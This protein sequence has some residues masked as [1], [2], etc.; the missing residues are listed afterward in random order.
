MTE[1]NKT[2]FITYPKTFENYKWYKPILVC[3]R[4]TDFFIDPCFWPPFFG[5]LHDLPYDVD[6][7]SYGRPFQGNFYGFVHFHDGSSTIF[8]IQ[9]YSGQA[10]FII[11]LHTGKM[12]L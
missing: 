1:N 8:R 9:D 4:D 12:E 10:F 7:W 3:I 6:S 5:K 11:S 2:D